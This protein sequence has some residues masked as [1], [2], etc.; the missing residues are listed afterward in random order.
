MTMNE[1]MW[2]NFK[3]ARKLKVDVPIFYI[4]TPYPKTQMRAE[5]EEMGLVTKNDFYQVRWAACQPQ[6]KIPQ[7]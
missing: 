2:E 6:D 5:L 4:S 7:R 1:D 3:L